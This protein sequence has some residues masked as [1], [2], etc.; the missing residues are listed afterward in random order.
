M[1]LR[2]ETETEAGAWERELKQQ[3]D[4]I[5]RSGAFR[6]SEILRHLLSYLAERAVAGATEPVKVREIATVVFG[7]SEDFDSQ[8]DSIV[9]VHTGRLRSKLAEYYLSEG[10][11]DPLV[12]SIP[13]GNYALSW[14][15]RQPGNG[16]AA[17]EFPL[18]APSSNGHAA[19]KPR[20]LRYHPALIWIG[21][22]LVA[23]TALLTWLAGRAF[24]SDGEATRNVPLALRT[25]WRP[26]I[27]G[28]DLPL[29][30]FSN[31]RLVGSLDDGLR[32]Y[33]PKVDQQQ[34][35]LDTYT[36]IGE[37]TGVF[38]ISRLLTML[39]QPLRAKHGSLL[40]WDEA[41][42]RNLIFVG[43]PLAQ[44]PL[45]DVPIFT[46]FE[47]RNRRAGIPGPSGAIVNLHP[48]K[49]EVPFY[50]GPQTRP[51]DFDYAVIALRRSV[52]PGHQTLALA[53]ITE[54][55]TEA[56]AE[57]VTRDDTTRILLARLSVKPNGNIPMF[58]AILRTTIRGGVPIQSELL[59]VHFH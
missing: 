10:A 15:C 40:T 52:N 19:A 48:R 3:A 49:G 55:G 28:N 27:G 1:S 58:E 18:P 50:F 45:Q 34:P 24:R 33:D 44:T 20:V 51:F 29:V 4:R 38:E 9:R 36:T 7:R 30:V 31:L 6:G 56:A 12:I 43:G 16:T 54:Y 13:K 26:F 41:R 23:V 25:F 46:D 22:A 17:V 11:E 47:F 2:L 39:H 14:R 21:L 8:T 42:D 32:E 37:V 35:V 53:G 59:S 5:V 57:F